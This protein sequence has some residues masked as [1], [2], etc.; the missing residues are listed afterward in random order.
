VTEQYRRITEQYK[1][2]QLRFQY[3]VKADTAQYAEVWEMNERE[4][5]QLVDQCVQGDRVVFEQ[6][7]GVEW[8]PPSTNFWGTAQRD[9]DLEQMQAEDR[10][11]EE[12]D[13]GMAVS[14]MARKMLEMLS[15]QCGF[16]VEDRV[17]K[18]IQNLEAE[19]KTAVLIDSVLKSLGIESKA[20]INKLLQYFTRT[21]ERDDG[22]MMTVLIDPQ[23]AI[24][25]LKHFVEFRNKSQMLQT[26]K[27]NQMLQLEA[28]LKDKKQ[29]EE[30]EYW[31]RMAHVI[32]ES[33]IRIW[34]ALENGLEKYVVLLQDRNRLIGETDSIRRQNDQL[35][36]L[37]NQY[38]TSKINQELYIDPMLSLAGLTSPTQ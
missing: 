16:L 28:R 18:V 19:Q 35:R 34:D 32:P 27:K 1:D 25:A 38:M 4:A 24:V 5:M 6:Q 3:F 23:D 26:S 7:L 13:A 36:S 30:R 33:N 10:E 12:E 9:H 17:K 21:A 20:E 8:R 2:L 31:N 29:R 15:E 11:E 37:L 14:D 22:E